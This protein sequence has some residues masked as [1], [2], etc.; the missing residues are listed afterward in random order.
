[1]LKKGSPMIDV[2]E[3]I[4][5]QD[6]RQALRDAGRQF[7]DMEAATIIHNLDLPPA[8]RRALLQQLAN[9]TQDE[10]VRAQITFRL[11]QEQQQLDWFRTVTEGCVFGTQELDEEY[12][13]EAMEAYFATYD[14]AFE[15]GLTLDKPFEIHKWRILQ[16]LPAEARWYPGS[17]GSIRFSAA[18]ELELTSL[19]ETGA[20]ESLQDTVQ[21]APWPVGT[22]EEHWPN[23]LFFEDR[24]VDLP[25]LYDA[26]D[27]VRVLDAQARHLDAAYDWAVVDTRQE[28]W[29]SYRE[30]VN[31]WLADVEA[32]RED[33]K[34]VLADFSDMQV[35][36]E[37]PRKDG[38]FTHDHINP[39]FLERVTEE[40]PAGSEEAQLR[41]VARAAV[42][43]EA[44]LDWLS[45]VLK[46]RILAAD[47]PS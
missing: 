29:Q 10:R 3:L 37:I 9:E 15:F 30:R 28:P 44:S 25:N 11:T 31:A 6:L 40:A 16:E 39:M 5:S 17:C 12:P 27:F 22:E 19:W 26:G 20:D 23:F 35:T 42:R 32:G 4:P 41:E 33:A 46:K 38:T 14:L 2:I 13:S 34:G 7:T 18:G 21:W 43:D 36:V 24:W 47:R 45:S 1:M 8:R